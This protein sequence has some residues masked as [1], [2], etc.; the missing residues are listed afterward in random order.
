[1]YVVERWLARLAASGFAGDFI[2]KGGMLLAAFGNRR[3]T[4]DAD[5]LARNMS[6][7][8][9]TVAVRVAGIAA[10]ASPDGEDGVEFLPATIRTRIIRDDALYVGVRVTMDAKIATADVRLRLDINFGDPVT[11]A[12]QTI[13]LP[14]LRPDAR[15]VRLLGYPV[16]TVL[17]EKIATAINLGAVSTRVRD[18]SDIYTLTGAHPIQHATAREA[19][20]ATTEFRGTELVP[21]SQA[22]GVLVQLRT[23][24]YLA[25]RRSLGVE[26]EHLPGKFSEVVDAVVTFADLLS[27][28]CPETTWDP[29][30]RRWRPT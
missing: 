13:E 18:W 19:L 2:L 3:P 28:E 9:D 5:V 21:L 14:A 26:G 11:P 12:P 4:Q 27:E 20:V 7:D 25:Y 23:Q 16:E 22:I 17:A 15:P 29:V 8:Q 6:A 30:K 10:L 24:T 1:M